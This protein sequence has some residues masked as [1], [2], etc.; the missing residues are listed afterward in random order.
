MKNYAL[1]VV[2]FATLCSFASCASSRKI[3]YLQD[4]EKDTILGAMIDHQPV[5]KPGDRLYIVVSAPVR[6]VAVPYNLGFATPPSTP[7]G[8]GSGAGE[9]GLSSLMSYLIDEQ[10]NIDFPVLGRMQVAGMTTSELAKMLTGRISFDVKD[11]TVNVSLKTE[12]RAMERLWVF[13]E[14][15]NLASQKIYSINHYRSTHA[16]VMAGVKV[17]F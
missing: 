6:E 11:P 1:L 3:L 14:G 4:L 16:G 17:V 5:I 13:V 9:Q 15:G 12:V 2:L 8:A 10:G 7:G